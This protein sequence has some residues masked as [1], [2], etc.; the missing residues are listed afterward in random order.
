M[1]EQVAR[2]DPRAKLTQAQVVATAWALLDAEGLE[3]FTMRRLAAEL[4]VAPMTV[5]GYFPDKDALL[6]A[7]LDA[8]SGELHI[9]RSQ[10]PW[11]DQLRELFLGLHRALAAHPFVVQ[12]R[13]R[14]SIMG[15]G[16]LRFTEAGLQILQGA[17]FPL[18]EAA[19]AFRPL[20]VY[21]FGYATFSPG[22]EDIDASRRRGLA[23]IAALPPE[24]Y[25]AVTEAALPLAA[26]LAGTEQY[27]YGLDRLLDGLEAARKV[28]SSRT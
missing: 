14:R 20:F 26:T 5:Y 3:A 10:G 2:V 28:W 1:A 11:R 23:I 18:E 12:L 25:P 16:V 17:G 15:P 9:P 4:G 21:T 27:E 13:E 7:V 22:R 6:D 24:Q 19:R 8:G